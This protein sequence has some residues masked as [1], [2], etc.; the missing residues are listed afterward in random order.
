MAAITMTC[1]K[2]EDGLTLEFREE[3]GQDLTIFIGSAEIELLREALLGASSKPAKARSVVAKGSA[4]TQHFD[5]FWAAYPPGSSTNPRRVAKD[6]CRSLWANMRLDEHWPA[7][8]LAID[9]LSPNWARDGYKFQPMA[10]TFLRQRRWE[11]MT[12][13]AEKPIV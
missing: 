3:G 6:A 2:A 5:A 8:Q 7:I 1:R 9:T 13:S 12:P 11:G 4:H 10:T